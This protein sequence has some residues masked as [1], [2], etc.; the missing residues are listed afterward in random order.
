MALDEKSIGTEITIAAN[1]KVNGIADS[2]RTT[3]YMGQ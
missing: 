3:G 1:H 2:Q